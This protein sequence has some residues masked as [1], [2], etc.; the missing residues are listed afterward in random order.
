MLQL[1]LKMMA[2]A[3]LRDAADSDREA[4][5]FQ[6]GRAMWREKT[7]ARRAAYKRGIIW[8]PK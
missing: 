7:A 3:M 8:V 5:A 2:A 1:I 6:Y 4:T